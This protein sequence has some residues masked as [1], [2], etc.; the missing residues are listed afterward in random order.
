MLLLMLL[1]LLLGGALLLMLLMLGLGLG[2]SP[3]VSVALML[4]L[5]RWVSWR[6]FGDGAGGR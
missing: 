3:F 4:W 5:L 1:L 2:W 6:A